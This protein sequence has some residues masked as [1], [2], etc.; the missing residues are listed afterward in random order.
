MHYSWVCRDDPK[1]ISI[2][3][4]TLSPPLPSSGG[5]S[6]PG[7]G[8]PAA[9]QH[10]LPHAVVVR[11]GASSAQRGRGLASSAD[12]R[13][14][15]SGHQRRLAAGRGS[16]NMQDFRPWEVLASQALQ[17][18]WC[19]IKWPQ[20]INSFSSLHYIS[21]FFLLIGLK[22]TELSWK[23]CGSGFSNIWL[24]SCLS[25]QITLICCCDL[26]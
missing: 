12:R 7:G 19:F 1:E 8:V 13:A 17:R 22:S 24:N 14:D 9:V 5:S 10:A 26:F 18:N 11:A 20:C 25:N 15:I 23:K 16:W 3:I 21:V 4:Q 6:Q 2:S